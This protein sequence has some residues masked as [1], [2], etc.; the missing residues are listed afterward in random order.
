MALPSATSRAAL[1]RI[2]ATYRTTSVAAM[3]IERHAMLT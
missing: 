1:Q 2:D 3:S